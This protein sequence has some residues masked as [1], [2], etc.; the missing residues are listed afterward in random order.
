MIKE[1]FD[2][3]FKRICGEF[4][5]LKNF[6]DSTIDPKFTRDQWFKTTEKVLESEANQFIEEMLAERI[7]TPKF[8]SDWWKIPSMLTTYSPSLKE[9]VSNKTT[10]RHKVRKCL[11]C[12]AK[13]S[14][15]R[16]CPKCLSHEFDYEYKCSACEDKGVLTV[17]SLDAMTRVKNAFIANEPHSVNGHGPDRTLTCCDCS[18]GDA[19]NYPEFTID[20]RKM[21]LCDGNESSVRLLEDKIRRIIS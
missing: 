1:E 20:R 16:K 14:R 12:G 15:G 17:F 21:V 10:E 9:A 2:K 5:I 19:L 13:F 3:W 18:A 11:K 4:P 8:A 7:T 6:F